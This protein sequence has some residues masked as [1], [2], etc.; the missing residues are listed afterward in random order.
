MRIFSFF[1]R[2]LVRLGMIIFMCMAFPVY[3]LVWLFSPMAFADMLDQVA[4]SVRKG[5]Y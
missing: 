4:K 2:L 1:N 3:L 5:R